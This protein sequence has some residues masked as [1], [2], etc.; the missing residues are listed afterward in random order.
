MGGLKDVREVGLGGGEGFAAVVGAVGGDFEAG[1]TGEIADAGGAG[2]VTGRDVDIPTPFDGFEAGLA[3]Q[4]N[5]IFRGKFAEGYGE[6]T[7]YEHASSGRGKPVFGK[8][9]K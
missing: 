9:L 1:F 8:G 7:R 4:F 2:V 5:K 6:G 3:D